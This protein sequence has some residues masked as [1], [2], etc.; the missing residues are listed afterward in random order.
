MVLLVSAKN[1]G[2]WNKNEGARVLTILKISIFQ[3][4]KGSQLHN[5]WW[6]LVEI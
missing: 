6:G 4:L 1:D 2:D 5:Q 3:T